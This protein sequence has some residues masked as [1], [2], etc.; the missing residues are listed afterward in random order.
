MLVVWKPFQPIPF[1]ARISGNGNVVRAVK[2]R[3]L[4]YEGSEECSCDP[5]VTVKCDRRKPAQRQRD[6]HIGDD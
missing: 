4:T 6:R 3:E 5:Y 2:D 1:A